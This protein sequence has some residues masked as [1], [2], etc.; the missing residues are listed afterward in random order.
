M[1]YWDFLN[2]IETLKER[3]RIRQGKSVVK[4]GVPESSKDM[5]KRLKDT[6]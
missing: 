1:S 3:N 6:W 4:E 2:I 5:I